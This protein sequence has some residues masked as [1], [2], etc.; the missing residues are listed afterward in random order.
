MKRFLSLVALFFLALPA[1]AALGPRPIEELV[2]HSDHV[3]VGT[4]GKVKT[5]VL[6]SKNGTDYLYQ[7]SFPIE[8]IEKGSFETGTVVTVECRQAGK[9]PRGWAGPQ[10]QNDVPSEGIKAR[11][12]VKESKGKFRLLEPNG[13]ELIVE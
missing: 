13:W 9:R 6:R 1:L 12:Y 8:K 7:W 2:E 4:V 5:E 11:L 10:G 3:W